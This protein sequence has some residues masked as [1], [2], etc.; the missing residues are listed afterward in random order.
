MEHLEKLITKYEYSARDFI[1]TSEI[2]N[3]LIELYKKIQEKENKGEE[4]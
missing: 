2:L 1:E 3:D 4:K